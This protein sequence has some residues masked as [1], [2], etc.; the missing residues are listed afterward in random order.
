MRLTSTRAALTRKLALDN[1]Q[2]TFAVGVFNGA[3]FSLVGALTD[4]SVVLVVFA[5]HFTDSTFLLGLAGMIPTA[6]WLMPQLWVSGY[7]QSRPL[8][9]PVYRAGVTVRSF[10]RLALVIAVFTVR[11]PIA[12]L[13]LFYL[14]ISTEA[15][16]GGVGGLAFMDM[17]GKVIA[18]EHRGLFFSWRIG[19]GGLLAIGGGAVVRAVL[20]PASPYPF[21]HN[22]GLLFGLAAAVAVVALMSWLAVDEPPIAA[23]GAS[24]GPLAQI[25]QARQ[26][27]RADANYRV[28]LTTRVALLLI[29]VTTPYVTVYARNV[30]DV[31]VTMLAIFPG[32]SAFVTL[33]STG[34]A[35]WISYRWGNRRLISLGAGVGMVTIVMIVLAAPLGISAD[36]AGVYFL[37]LYVIIAVRDSML[38]VALAA[39]NINIAPEARRPLYIG[40]ANTL[41]G[42][43]VLASSAMGLLVDAIGFQAFFLLMLAPMLFGLW[44]VRALQD[45][46]VRRSASVP[47]LAEEEATRN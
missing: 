1:P 23:R 43:V 21:P 40:F 37:I 35:G 18:P 17:V 9:K 27:W 4:P 8:S 6:G 39:L 29:L 15:L 16:A 3:L 34:A 46:S 25:R 22:F 2:R 10:A 47:S 24:S 33:V 31:P 30:F 38:N 28:Y 11:D 20:D 7:L 41:M 42:T 14:I 12:L 36:A 13:V 32:V 19:L 26:V 5:A 44:R 45:P